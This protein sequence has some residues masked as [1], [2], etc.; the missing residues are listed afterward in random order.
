MPLELPA[1]WRARYGDTAGAQLVAAFRFLGLLDGDGPSEALKGIAASTGDSRKPLLLD[2]LRRSYGAV[3]FE[4]L[5]AASLTDLR[6]WFTAYP[7][8]GHT[9]RKAISFLL[10]AARACGQTL[11][12]ELARSV[13]SKVAGDVA[14]YARGGVLTRGKPLHSGRQQRPA[15][16][17]GAGPVGEETYNVRTVKL[18]SGGTV[19][20]TLDLDLF[21]LSP[22]DKEFVLKLVALVRDYGKTGPVTTPAG[23]VTNGHA[24]AR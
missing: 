15:G 4:K 23:S 16:R 10:N 22:D 11:S 14:G 7:L 18:A 8:A 2:V 1:L 5:S 13:R 12:S 17:R 6:Q 3:P 20:V 24:V 19:T 21:E 9:Q